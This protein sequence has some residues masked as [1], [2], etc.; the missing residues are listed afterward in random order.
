MDNI[1]YLTDQIES[2]R[3]DLEG[4]TSAEIA[5]DTETTMKMAALSVKV[6]KLIE[7]T[8]NLLR[9]WEQARGMVTLVKWLAAIGGSLASMYLFFKGK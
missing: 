9:L 1:T 3:L 2:I 4:H 7:S 5:R 8:E 6:D